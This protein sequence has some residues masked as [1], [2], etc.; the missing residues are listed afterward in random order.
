MPLGQ[1][2]LDAVPAPVLP[3]GAF[4]PHRADGLAALALVPD[5]GRHALRDHRAGARHLP[6]CCTRCSGR[7]AGAGGGARTR[8]QRVPRAGPAAPRGEARRKLAA[9]TCSPAGAARVERLQAENASCAR[10]LGL[11][12]ALTVQHGRRGAVRRADPFSRKVVIDRGADGRR[13][14]GLA[15]DQR[16][17][18]ARP[19]DARLPAVSRGDAAGR[20]GRRHSGVLNT[21][22]GR[23]GAPLAA[24]PRTAAWSCASWPATPTCRWATCCTT[25]GVDG[26]YPRAA[27]GEGECRWMRR[28]R[29]SASP[30]SRCAGRPGRVRHVLVLEPLACRPDGPDAGAPATAASARPPKQRPAPDPATGQQRAAARP[31]RCSSG[32]AC[33]WRASCSTCCRWAVA[34]RRCRT[35]WPWCWCSGTCTS[36][37]PRVGIGVAFISAVRW[38]CTDAAR[39][40]AST[41]WPTRC[42][43]LSSPSPST[44]GCWVPVPSQAVQILPLFRRPPGRPGGAA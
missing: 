37:A 21:R 34:C 42:W 11:R 4:G 6:P 39:C 1:G 2:P 33:C 9:P 40:S 19:G 22:T 27:G 8:R 20:Q 16:R 10:L 31:T 36:R 28:S 43:Q 5:G 29:R 23:C 7:R 18:R 38:T 26:V 3:P 44:G 32:P 14:A 41:R 13:G 25:S 24:A 12:P 17:R 15:G 30:A 35:C